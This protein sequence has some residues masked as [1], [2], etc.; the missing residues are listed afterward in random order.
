MNR[1]L[2]KRVRTNLKLPLLSS[3]MN[4][5]LL[6]GAR[7]CGLA[8]MYS[9]VAGQSVLIVSSYSGRDMTKLY[10]LLFSLMNSKGSYLEIQ[11]SM[12]VLEGRDIL[13]EWLTYSWSQK[14]PIPGSTRQYLSTSFPVS[15][16]FGLATRVISSSKVQT[17]A[18]PSSS[19]QHTKYSPVIFCQQFISP[20]KP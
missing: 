18:G 14:N 16:H 8:L 15:D 9:T 5:R 11:N 2:P 6:F 1:R 20:E 13:N 7:Y 19:A 10:F 4:P 3:T 17:H 12:N